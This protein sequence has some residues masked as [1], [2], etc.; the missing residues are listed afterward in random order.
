MDSY[1]N[2]GFNIEGAWNFTKQLRKDDKD[3]TEL[4][5]KLIELRRNANINYIIGNFSKKV[6]YNF[7][8]IKEIVN[9]DKYAHASDPTYL[10]KFN[11]NF[12]HLENL[13]S[14]YRRLQQA[15]LDYLKIKEEEMCIRKE[16]YELDKKGLNPEEKNYRATELVKK[17][18]SKS[19]KNKAY[20]EYIKLESEYNK[21]STNLNVV[22][23]KNDLLKTIASIEDS[24]K[25]LAISSDNKEKIQDIINDTR[26]DVI[27]FAI[28]NIKAKTELDKLSNRYGITYNSEVN[29]VTHNNYKEK[30]NEP[31]VNQ[32][33]TYKDSKIFKPSAE[34]LTNNNFKEDDNKTTNKKD[35]GL[36]FNKDE[37]LGTVHPDE[38]IGPY[39]GDTPNYANNT[40]PKEEPE[41][42]PLDFNLDE[43]KI[44]VVGRR[45]CNWL[46]KNKKKI[47]I[48]VGISLLI[49]AAV[50]A[51]QY[52]I[53]AIV[54]MIETQ[55][56]ATLSS[57]MI[58]N[59]Q[60]W[61]LAGANQAALHNANNALA[62]VIQTMTN[63]QALF[64]SVSG[65]WTFG[66]TELSQFA[67]S[68]AAKAS[69]ATNAVSSLSSIATTLGIGGLS[70]TS[71]GAILPK[72]SNTYINILN[73]IKKLE[74][75]SK[76][77]S[78]DLIDMKKTEILNIINNNY[79]LSETEKKRLLKRINKLV[80]LNNDLQ[81]KESEG[82]G[83]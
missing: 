39:L 41:A 34:T 30:S 83:R 31:I 10:D 59:A 60:T 57:A 44:K 61:H 49:A 78:S 33:Q 64:N 36:S 48:V 2:A 21:Y 68:A 22:D 51:M 82:L 56:I 67:V 42:F 11:T 40:L 47:L 9:Y 13:F 24:Y 74:V 26:E 58:N 81:N 18:P 12:E 45:A 43:P 38:Q 3:E 66:G 15:E 53:P 32:E 23:F 37:Y 70:I 55:Q 50:V 63:S 7:D 80:I 76:N 54:H 52:L 8:K 1:T 27:K 6:L 65:I 17:L 71:L 35:T 62:S 25:L 4:L 29:D 14:K 79:D 69:A 28:D 16:I 20:D 73:T 72:R 5:G 46:N 19:A 77:N 75:A